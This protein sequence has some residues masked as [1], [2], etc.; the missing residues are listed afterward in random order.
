MLEIPNKIYIYLANVGDNHY[1][2]DPTDSVADK[3]YEEEYIS[4][5]LLSRRL[6][7]AVGSEE[8]DRLMELIQKIMED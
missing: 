4:V 3:K 5:E 7:D 6:K 8:R 1:H 2:I